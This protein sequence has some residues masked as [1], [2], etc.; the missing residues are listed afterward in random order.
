[1]KIQAD[2]KIIPAI[3]VNE[4]R[5]QHKPYIQRGYLIVSTAQK[6]NPKKLTSCLNSAKKSAQQCRNCDPTDHF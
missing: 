5:K 6:I 3:A 2:Q 1:M 4:N